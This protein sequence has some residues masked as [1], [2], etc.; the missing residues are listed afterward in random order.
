MGSPFT[1]IHPPDVKQA[2]DNLQAS[3]K[4]ARARLHHALDSSDTVSASHTGGGWTSPQELA[5][6]A[7]AWED[8]VIALVNEMETLGQDLHDSA[9][10]FASDDAFAGNLLNG[11]DFLGD[12]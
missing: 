12:V 4:D 3:A 2:A 7:H 10:S 6:C 5:D 11:I 8:H 9:G 1:D